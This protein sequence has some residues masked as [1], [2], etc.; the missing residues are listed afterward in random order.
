VIRRHGSLATLVGYVV[1]PILTGILWMV[2]AVEIATHAI[3]TNEIRGS[4]M[5]SWAALVAYAG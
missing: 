2:V 4:L 3:A 1:P 5:R